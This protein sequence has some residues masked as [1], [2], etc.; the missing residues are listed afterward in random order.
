[1]SLSCPSWRAAAATVSAAALLAAGA[2]TLSYAA[3]GPGLSFRRANH[4]TVTVKNTGKGPALALV[5]KKKFPALAVS[6]S[7]LVKKLNADVLDGLD[8]SALAPVTNR[9]TFGAVGAPPPGNGTYPTV[10][11][12]AGNYMVQLNAVG[13]VPTDGQ[14]IC[15]VFD[16]DE[17]FADSSYSS[18]I[19]STS[20]A[21]FGAVS[22]SGLYR[23]RSGHP[24]AVGCDASGSVSMYA[25][26]TVTT[27]KLMGVTEST[28]A[29]RPG[30][31]PR[32]PVTH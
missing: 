29:S 7:K 32:E 6:N 26:L 5:S 27:R 22:A 21:G 11:L 19:S 8:S 12:P 2:G 14:L 24:M 20:T 3:G 16:R 4:H 23:A 31:S 25:P 28:V 1:M 17:F 30:T 18:F 9:L 15:F 13:G 10:D